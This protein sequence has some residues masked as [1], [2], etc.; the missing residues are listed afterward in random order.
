[1]SRRRR[2]SKPD[3]VENIAKLLLL[4]IIFLALSIG[5]IKH[6]QE[7]FL[8]I[9]VI[10]ISIIALGVLSVFLYLYLRKYRTKASAQTSGY[11]YMR[12]SAPRQERGN[13]NS[14]KPSQ[15]NSGASDYTYIPTPSTLPSHQEQNEVIPAQMKEE[16][17]WTLTSIYDALGKIDWYQFEKFCSTLLSNEGYT[18]ERK[19][20]AH[21]DGGVDL[22]ANKDNDTVLVQCKHWKTWDIKPKTVREMVGTMT[23]NQTS[24]GAIYTIKGPSKAALELAIQQGIQIEEGYGLANRALRQLSKEQLDNILKTTVHHCPKCEAEMVLRE[25]NFGPFWGCSRYPKCGSKLK[26]TGAL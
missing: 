6:F 2:D 3:I 16:T 20:G 17:A 10:L 25:G 9:I 21:P 23:I 8:R 11:S 15:A 18:V 14:N 1:M 24:K 26:H 7:I 12:T 5:G 19:G 13:L 4:G 22:I